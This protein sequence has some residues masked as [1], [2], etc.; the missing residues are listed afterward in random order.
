MR[1]LEWDW[2]DLPQTSMPRPLAHV[3]SVSKFLGSFLGIIS[4]LQGRLGRKNLY[5]RQLSLRLPFPLGSPLAILSFTTLAPKDAVPHTTGLSVDTD[6]SLIPRDSRPDITVKALLKAVTTR[7]LF[8]LVDILHASARAPRVVWEIQPHHMETALEE[9]GCLKK[10]E[11]G[12]LLSRS[13][14]PCY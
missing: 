5:Q 4:I 12:Y 3:L 13:K 7:E 14:D 1:W 6:P 8:W 2:V 11:T 10:R 9:G